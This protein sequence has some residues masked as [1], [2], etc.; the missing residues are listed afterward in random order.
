MRWLLALAMTSAAC[1]G[2][3]TFGQDQTAIVRYQ[4]NIKSCVTPPG[5]FAFMPDAMAA[6]SG[7]G[8][9]GSVRYSA[10]STRAY[11]GLGPE[12]R[13]LSSAL[14]RVCELR[15]QG[16]ITSTQAADLF[17]MVTTDAADLLDVRRR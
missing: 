15:A 14:F 8:V 12:S 13:Y 11:E 1:A 10:T 5:L 3:P 9:G 16:L 2:V 4:D 7:Y 6:A 17:R